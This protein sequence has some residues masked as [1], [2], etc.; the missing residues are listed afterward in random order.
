[1]LKNLNI[2]FA[3]LIKDELPHRALWEAYF[4]R[5]PANPIILIH[6]YAG[7]CVDPPP[8][9]VV[10]PTAPTTWGQTMQAHLRLLTYAAA[11]GADRYVLLSES[12]APC[13]PP[14]ILVERLRPEVSYFHDTR[15]HNYG[16][17]QH[18]RLRNRTI[19]EPYLTKVRWGEQWHHLCRRHV[20]LLLADTAAQA[21]FADCKIGDNEHWPLTTLAFHRQERLLRYHPRPIYTYWP[22]ASNHPRTFGELTP[23]WLKKAAAARAPFIRKIHRDCDLKPLFD[24]IT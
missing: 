20:D 19:A 4:A 1:M 11:L 8:G 15:R 23:G 13:L 9:A 14:H 2:A 10:V 6:P 18:R 12:C 7:H 24:L 3:F 16:P 5:L 21:A 17:V 22:P